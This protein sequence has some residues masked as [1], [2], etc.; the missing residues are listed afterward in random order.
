L[1]E[2]D[3]YTVEG[4]GVWTQ[5]INEATPAL[6]GL[7]NSAIS[8][9]SNS[10]ETSHASGMAAFGIMAGDWAVGVYGTSAN[11]DGLPTD[12]VPGPDQQELGVVNGDVRTLTLNAYFADGEILGTV[13]DADGPTPVAGAKITAY[14]ADPIN[15]PAQ[16][17]IGAPIT[18]ETTSDA[19][20][21]F[22]LPILGGAWDVQATILDQGLASSIVP[23]TMLPGGDLETDGNDAI[24]LASETINN[25]NLTL[26]ID[27]C[28]DGVQNG[29][30]TGIDCGGSCDE[31]LTPVQDVSIST[32]P[33]SPAALATLGTV[34]LVSQANGDD[35]SGDYEYR[36]GV[37][38]PSGTWSIVRDYDESNTA[39]WAPTEIGTYWLEVKARNVGSTASYEANKY[40]KFIVADTVAEPVSTVTLTTTP[41]SPAAL[42]TL[43]TVQ[44]VSQANGDDTSGDYEYRYG[45][46]APSGTW[47]IVRDYDESN[48]ADWTPT[49]IG[50]YWLE[51]KTRN[52]GSTASYEANKYLKFIVH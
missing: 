14:S 37:M 30:E 44:L 8:Y 12:L 42:A 28:S 23:I 41:G 6:A 43:G 22:H 50:T 27:Q 3:T 16:D 18:T 48:T 51:I 1:D 46:M 38:A 33:G 19:L 47:S 40:L 26:Q 7:N 49:E 9:A 52:V 31:C 25:V 29:D 34:Q 36:Y 13:F 5:K 10:F 39:D 15:G 2:T 21:Q 35:T 45:V 24:D 11:V 32:T 17:P 4:M 20:G